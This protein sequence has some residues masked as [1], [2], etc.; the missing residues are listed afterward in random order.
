M[1]EKMFQMFHHFQLGIF[2][3]SSDFNQYVAYATQNFILSFVKQNG[4]FNTKSINTRY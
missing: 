1:E 2:G 4:S 3:I